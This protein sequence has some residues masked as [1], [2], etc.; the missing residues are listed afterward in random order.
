MGEQEAAQ[1]SPRKANI[2]YHPGH[3]PQR[4]QLEY[5]AIEIHGS[6]G[7]MLVVSA[8]L[9]PQKVLKEADM[10]VVFDKHKRVIMVG[11]LN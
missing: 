8:N 5:T 9:P 3:F 11:D 10:D 1:P 4:Q 7:S 2:R 6:L